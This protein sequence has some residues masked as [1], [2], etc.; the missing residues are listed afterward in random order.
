MI[1][2]MIFI[3]CVT[4]RSLS[5]GSQWSVVVRTEARGRLEG[6]VRAVGDQP[7]GCGRGAG[8]DGCRRF[9]ALGRGPAVSSSY[10]RPRAAG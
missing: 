9:W 5:I 8:G 10:G 6:L 1:S 2:R 3:G 7:V 4:D